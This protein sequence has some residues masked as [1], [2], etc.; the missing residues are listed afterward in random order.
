MRR[1]TADLA[2]VDLSAGPVLIERDV[3]S[4]TC[5][6]RWRLENIQSRFGDIE[7]TVGDDDDD[8]DV[9]V[10]MPLNEYLAYAERQKDDAPLYAFDDSVLDEVPEL[11]ENYSPPTCLREDWFALLP[12]ASRPP[13]RWLLVGAARSGSAPHVDPDSTSA[14]NT[15]V[16]GAKRWVLFPP[17]VDASDALYPSAVSSS[18]TLRDDEIDDEV[19]R[20]SA[21]HWLHVCYPLLAELPGVEVVQ[22]PGETVCVPHGWHHCAVNLALSVA[23]TANFVDA[24]N[25][26]AAYRALRA[27][28][29]GLADKWRDRV[30]REVGVAL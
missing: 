7:L 8:E 17:D 12:R 4:W 2:E 3:G 1:C 27:H 22:Q 5:D 18:G 13:H 26:A 24:T 29:V 20:S 25:A 11:G 21:S 6:A 14:W 30:L 23:V 28:D 9:A 16:S 10:T 15:L 19:V